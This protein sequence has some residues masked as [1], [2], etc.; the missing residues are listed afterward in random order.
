MHGQVG[1]WDCL[2]AEYTT[3]D[4]ALRIFKSTAAACAAKQ[5]LH[6]HPS[7]HHPV[8][9]Y[10]LLKEPGSESSRRLAHELVEEWHAKPC[11]FDPF[12][13]DVVK[14]NNTVDELLSKKCTSKLEF[15]AEII[16]LENVTAE[17]NNASIRRDC[18]RN[19]QKKTLDVKDLDSMWVLRQ[20]KEIM[21]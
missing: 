6:V 10:A 5:Q 1:T 3:H 7:K 4:I 19:T 12:W 11:T 18:H 15:H 9:G 14:D 20:E 2:P 13:Y 8:R 21:Q 16:E 17:T